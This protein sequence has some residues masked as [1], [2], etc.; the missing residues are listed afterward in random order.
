MIVPVLDPTDPL[1]RR[2]DQHLR[3]VCAGYRIDPPSVADVLAYADVL[4]C[5]DHD[6]EPD[7]GG[8]WLVD[9]IDAGEV[10]AG[11][12]CQGV[13]GILDRFARLDDASAQEVADLAEDARF[14][15]PCAPCVLV[16]TRHDGAVIVADLAGCSVHVF[17]PR[18]RRRSPGAFLV[19]LFRA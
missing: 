2:A 13:F 16:L 18:P 1:T 8:D 19:D 4:A 7:P 5:E 15:S 3:E 11:N 17:E 10:A 6:G 14:G 9:Y 12:R